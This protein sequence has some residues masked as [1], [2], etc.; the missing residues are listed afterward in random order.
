MR[1]LIATPLYPPDPG[2]PATYAK[3][4]EE[5]L[6]PLPIEV[7]LVKFSDVRHLPKGVRHVAYFWRVLRALKGVD[8]VLALDPV[9]VG[10]PALLAALI[11]RKKFVLK[12]VGDYA[13][14]QGRQRWG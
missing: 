13:W 3:A 7:D 5:G 4:L 9:S 12:V 2:G 11:A 14:E 6:P 8:V 10:L 1:L